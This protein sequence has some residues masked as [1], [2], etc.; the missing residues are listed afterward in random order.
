VDQFDCQGDWLNI[1]ET[2]RPADEVIGH[3][4]AA[5]ALSKD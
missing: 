3:G 1:G 4:I 2:V 5:V